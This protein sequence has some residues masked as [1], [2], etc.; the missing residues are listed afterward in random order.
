[1]GTVRAPV[2]C[3]P[4]VALVPLQ[5]P[6]AVHDIALVEFHVSV[7][8]PPLVMDAGFAVRVTVAAPDNVTVAVAIMLAPPAPLQ[9]N[10]NDVVAVSAPVLWEP[11]VA[12]VPLQPPE[13]VHEVALVELHVRVDAA[14]LFTVVGVALMVAVVAG[15]IELLLPPPQAAISRA[16]QAASNRNARCPESR[17]GRSAELDRNARLTTLH[18]EQALVVMSCPR[19][20]ARRILRFLIIPA[21]PTTVSVLVCHSSYLITQIES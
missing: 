13:A 18:G 15:S 4:L 21:R 3:E 14:P 19:A 5:P 8:A 1:M 16:A 9:I 17:F 7:E 2:L 20:F 6:E 10:E 12:F 11:L